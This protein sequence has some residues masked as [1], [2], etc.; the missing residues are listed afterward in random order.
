MPHDVRCDRSDI[1]ALPLCAGIIEPNAYNLK[2]KLPGPLEEVRFI[3]IHNTVEPF[4]AW[5]ERERVNNR[6]DQ[7]AVSFHFAVD[8]IEAVQLLPLDCHAWHAADGKGDGNMHS[9]AI[10]ICRS[11]CIGSDEGLYRRAEDN[12]VILAAWLLK[13]YN[14]PIDALR[15][16]QDWSGKYCP[17]R[18][19]DEKRWEEFK[20]K[21]A[22][23]MPTAT[24]RPIAGMSPQTA[25]AVIVSRRLDEAGN[26]RAV[27]K[28]FSGREFAR[29][30]DM[31]ADQ[32]ERKIKVVDISVWG[33]EADPS[34]ILRSFRTAG[35]KVRCCYVPQPGAP[36]WIRRG[37]ITFSDPDS[38]R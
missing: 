31:I 9:I 18:I 3:T 36:E 24:V 1:Q 8:E 2:Y 12:A 17:H 20:L 38:F 30:E 10:E 23:A 29:L 14:L 19:L 28:S 4:S 6:R 34:P 5:Q 16:H 25:E 37:E 27:Y 7:V 13:K 33:G 32:Q 11:V 15:K 26:E 22:A 21:V 35:I